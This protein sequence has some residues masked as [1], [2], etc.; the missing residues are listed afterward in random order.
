MALLSQRKFRNTTD[1]LHDRCRLSSAK[2]LAL[3]MST[4]TLLRFPN[5]AFDPVRFWFQLG[6]SNVSRDTANDRRRCWP[7]LKQI[8]R[9]IEASAA[10]T[11]SIADT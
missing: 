5:L 10:T 8:S 9:I 11:Q 3:L 7:S 4:A 1:R 6:S 2:L